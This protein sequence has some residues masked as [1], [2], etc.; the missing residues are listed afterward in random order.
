VKRSRLRDEAC[1]SIGDRGYFRRPRRKPAGLATARLRW[2]LAMASPARTLRGQMTRFAAVGIWNTLLDYVLF[3]SITK[4]F[5]IPLDQVWIAKVISGTVA[6]ANSFY[7]NRYW[8]FHGR[9]HIIRQATLFIAANA[10][11][12]YAVQTPLT[13]LFS[14][15][16]PQPGRRVF[17]FLETIGL[18][19]LLPSVLTEDLTIKTVAFVIAVSVSMTCNFLAYRFVVFRPRRP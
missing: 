10:F 19:D 1:P 8:V 17:D 11:S 6:I 14:S 5:H 7:L 15:I 3:I 13:Q 18:P 2:R 16:V 9:G 12:V 4:I